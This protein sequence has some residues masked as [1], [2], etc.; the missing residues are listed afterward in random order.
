MRVS[1]AL[2]IAIM[3]VSRLLVLTLSLHLPCQTSQLRMFRSRQVFPLRRTSPPAEGSQLC[4]MTS[5]NEFQPPSLSDYVSLRAESAVEASVKRAMEPFMSE[6]RTFKVDM[7][8]DLHSFKVEMKAEMK[9]FKAEMKAEMKEF[10]AEMKKDLHSFKVEM[11]AEMK[12]FKA[13]MK[14]NLVEIK[15]DLR[16]LKSDVAELKSIAELERSAWKDV[17]RYAGWASVPSL[18]YVFFFKKES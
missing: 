16:V 1:S 12:E 5:N 8:E 3:V 9:E 11:K 4:G 2:A 14:E 13:E 7:K 17:L 15:E 18:F 6:L 10:K